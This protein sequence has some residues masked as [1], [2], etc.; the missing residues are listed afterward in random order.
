M[1]AT[2]HRRSKLPFIAGK[3]LL[4]SVL[5]G[6]IAWAGVFLVVSTLGAKIESESVHGLSSLPLYPG[7]N[8]E[9]HLN[10]S[11]TYEEGTTFRTPDSPFTVGQFYDDYMLAH[12]WVLLARIDNSSGEAYREFVWRSKTED[13]P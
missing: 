11:G 3:S 2:L 6:L 8:I 1:S 4:I 9:K 13:E 10:A 12:G 5:V 7:A